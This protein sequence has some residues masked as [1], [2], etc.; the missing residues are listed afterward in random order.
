MAKNKT[1]AASA[2]VINDQLAERLS[3]EDPEPNRNL[4][5]P[6]DFN[7]D[8][9]K[10]QQDMHTCPGCG[11]DTSHSSP[12]CQQCQDDIAADNR[13]CTALTKSG[14]PCSRK[15]VSGY[16]ACTQHIAR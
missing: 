16:N 14:K 4:I 13:N 12:V 2:V 5:L 1:L 8:C 11:A 3:D 10:C 7:E 15:A 9:H 6:K